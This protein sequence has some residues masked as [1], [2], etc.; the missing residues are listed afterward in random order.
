MKNEK[1]GS[2]TM[3]MTKAQ[4]NKLH[5]ER[6]ERMNKERKITQEEELIRREKNEYQ[7]SWRHAHKDRV[8]QYNQNYWRKKVAERQ[9]LNE[10][11]TN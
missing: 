5:K 3:T 7:N 11:N 10:R 4:L 2:V 9:K 1:K 6:V 8:R